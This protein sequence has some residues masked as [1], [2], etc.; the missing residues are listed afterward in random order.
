MDGVRFAAGRRHELQHLLPMLA[1]AGLAY[2]TIL[3]A[4][5]PFFAWSDA[6][7]VQD[8]GAASGRM[9][10]WRALPVTLRWTEPDHVRLTND[11]RAL[12]LL[13]VGNGELMVYDTKLDKLF[14]VPVADA[15]AS[16]DRDCV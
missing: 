13:G 9:A 10:P 1:V 2:G 4:M 12:R 3:L 11:C 6:V 8:G 14:R 15:S 16:V 7:R 5:L